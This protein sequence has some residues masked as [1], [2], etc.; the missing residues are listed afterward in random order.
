[1]EGPDGESAL[2]SYARATLFRT[3]PD[4]RK[5]V[6]GTLGRTRTVFGS[7]IL[8]VAIG[9][10]LMFL[11]LSLVAS[12]VREG[13]EGIIKA[14]AVN[15]ERGIRTVLDD[16][17]GIG[18]ARLFYEH[19]LISSLY[20][21]T[22]PPAV[23]RF[24]G[25]NLPTYI[26]SRSFSTVLIDLATRGPNAGPYAAL[27][28]APVPSVAQ[29]RANVRRIPSPFVQRAFLSAIDGAGNDLNRVRENLEAWFDSA[30]S[31]VSGAYRRRTQLY[32]FVIGAVIA[33]FL[34]VNTFT[35]AD[36]LWR[37]NRARAALV[38]RAGQLDSAYHQ[39][40]SDST[41]SPQEAQRLYADL[42]SLSLPIGW[43]RRPPGPPRS[44]G[45]SAHFSYWAKQV[46]GLALTAFA[47]MLGAPFWFDTLNKFVVVRST[48]KP[49][50]K[51]VPAASEDRQT[52]P[53]KDRA[54]SGAVAG[55]AGVAVV[56]SS[57]APGSSGAATTGTASQPGLS[58]ATPPPPH[59]DQ[60]WSSGVEEGIL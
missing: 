4:V 31:S 57:V 12:A 27:Q 22:F 23:Q 58:T 8:E 39:V 1:M 16:P 50:E 42:Q 60:E 17:K 40:I 44:A 38:A 25:R 32:L 14:R 24:L 46:F 9:L 41:V 53:T 45:A 26:P 34:N 59:E 49:N 7:T 3:Q 48:V 43:D 11:L 10:V 19:P 51:T 18:L 56:A 35:I 37:D 2:M 21:D 55:T 20:H 15:L 54:G 30:M 28:D 6:P 5:F 13:I 36:H 47:I 29:L 52:E 33:A